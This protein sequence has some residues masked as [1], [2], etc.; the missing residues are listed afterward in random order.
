MSVLAPLFLAGAAAIGLPILAHLIRRRPRGQTTFSS[1]MF[2]RPSPPRLTR[3]SRLDQWP[4]LLVRSLV[5]LLLAIAFARPFWR[6]AAEADPGVVGQRVVLL[7]DTSGSLRRSGLWTESLRTAETVLDGLDPADRLAVVAFDRAPR[8]VAGFDET[9]RLSATQRRDTVL[10]RIRSMRPSWDATDLGRALTFAAEITAGYEPPDAVEP[11]ANTAG[12]PDPDEDRRADA[13]D[14]GHL[15][16]ISDLQ[17]GSQV[18]SLQSFAWPD[19]LRLDVRRVDPARPTNA[20]ARILRPASGQAAAEVTADASNADDSNPTDA[21][22]AGG[23]ANPVDPTNTRDRAERTRIRVANSDNADTAQFRL[24]WGSGEASVR[25]ASTVPV[26][27][28]PGETRVVRMPAAESI[29]ASLIL[30]G[31]ADDFD[32]VRYFVQNEPRSATV[33]YIGPE[34]DDDDSQSEASAESADDAAP[35]RDP[36][37]FYY[38]SRLPLGDR[39]RV[40]EVKRFEPAE[41]DPGWDPDE[42]PLVVVAGSLASDHADRLTDYLDSGGHVLA[43]ITSAMAD[44]GGTT[45]LRRIS[46]DDAVRI[47][48]SQVNDY[49]MLSRI[50]FRNRAFS[51][52]ADPQFND[53]TQIRFWAHRDV[54]PGDDA[55]DTPATFDDG[56]AAILERPVGDG[57]LAV[58]TSGWH[59]D[60]SQFALSTKFLPWMTGLLKTERTSTESSYVVG[61]TIGDPP[62]DGA[63]LSDPDEEVLAESVGSDG[64][65]ATSRGRF[66]RPGIH[67]WI[68]AD[69][70][71]PVAVN[72]DESESRTEPMSEQV[73]EQYGVTLGEA[74][75]A[76]ERQ[77]QARQLRDLELERRQK[78]WQWLLAAALALVGLEAWLGGWLAGRSSARP[79]TAINA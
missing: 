3:R 64:D 43:V 28:P 63:R 78:L 58:I 62:I 66:E 55:W 36:G 40:I 68:A 2:L 39:Q 71:Y 59:P 19:G 20:T 67:V 54:T 61:D 73:L 1:L 11:D 13:A 70:R 47:T 8:V 49:A 46:G 27:V 14:P 15:V 25:E 29:D 10:E 69:E 65:L 30:R 35:P 21:S 57:S 18:E 51:A 22:N 38:L 50:D 32:N 16:L 53:F 12:K 6:S 60:D 26:Q 42:V 24:S 37:L 75:S 79:E 31:D 72:L 76:G 52:L 5:I 45:T 77:E 41:I 48:E 17:S 34:P 56:A 4:L 9:D 74:V 23:P 7:I 33:P 44:A